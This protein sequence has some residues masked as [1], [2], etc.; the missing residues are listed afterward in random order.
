M[1]LEAQDGQV[2]NTYTLLPREKWEG[3]QKPQFQQSP[4]HFTEFAMAIKD[5]K[6]EIAWSNFENAGR[7]TETILLGNV[8]LRAGKRIEWD[9]VNL[10]VTNAADAQQYVSREYRK[11]WE[12]F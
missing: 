8:A 1:L 11:G 6:P 7:L 10:K 3:H 12:V 5:S 9:A 4:G 2:R